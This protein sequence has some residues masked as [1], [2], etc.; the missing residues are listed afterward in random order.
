MKFFGDDYIKM[1]VSAGVGFNNSATTS[2]TPQFFDFGGIWDGSDSAIKEK[3]KIE[4]E[5][6]KNAPP[7]PRETFFNTSH[8]MGELYLEWY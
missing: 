4:E 2:P 7:S 8:A 1:H 5:R 3:K 6:I